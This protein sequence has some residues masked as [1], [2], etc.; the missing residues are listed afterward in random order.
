MSR[1]GKRYG[2]P[3]KSY[4]N[5]TDLNIVRAPQQGTNTVAAAGVNPPPQ[6]PPPQPSGRPPGG[7][8]SGMTTPDQV[9]P[10]DAPTGR[11]SEPVTAGL[12]TGPGATPPSVA[13]HSA[14]LAAM[15]RHL[16]WLVRAANQPDTPLSIIN[17]VRFLQSQVGQ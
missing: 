4:S 15:S 17:F 6:A 8:P 2:Q 11:P 5:R 13:Q 14:D 3:G 9:T 7:P 16:P 12:P 10:L 1:G